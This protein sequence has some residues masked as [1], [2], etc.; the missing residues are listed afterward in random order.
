M[1]IDLSCFRPLTIDPSAYLTT[2]V[3]RIEAPHDKP[4]CGVF[5]GRHQ[6]FRPEE[7]DRLVPCIEDDEG[8]KVFLIDRPG[9]IA[10]GHMIARWTYA[11]IGWDNGV[12]VGH[13]YS[14][15][16]T[17]QE[18]AQEDGVYDWSVSLT[19]SN[20][21]PTTIILPEYRPDALSRENYKI[22]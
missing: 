13:P 21:R 1:L 6:E 12:Y 19:P 14:Y 11:A 3:L 5:A 4:G 15:V 10:H 2:L 7:E 9:H 20:G 18:L 16:L 17:L 22:L 8:T